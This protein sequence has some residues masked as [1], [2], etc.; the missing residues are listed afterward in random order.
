MYKGRLDCGFDFEV[1]EERADS[2]ELVEAL[3]EAEESRIAVPKVASLLYGEEQKKKLID[4]L[5]EENG[6]VPY[7]K[8]E[9]AITDTFSKISELKNS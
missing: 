8:V 6:F 4:Y 9:D 7:D 5:R 1:E 3:A 2:F